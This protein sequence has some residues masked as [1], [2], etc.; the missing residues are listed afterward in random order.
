MSAQRITEGAAVVGLGTWLVGILGHLLDQAFPAQRAEGS[1]GA[2]W[3]WWYL[4]LAVTWIL[5]LVFGLIR[6]GS[7]DKGRP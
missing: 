7:D 4:P 5:T 1:Q 2:Y 6:M 3:A